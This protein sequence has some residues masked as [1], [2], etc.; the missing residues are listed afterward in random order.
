[1]QTDATYRKTLET[2]EPATEK[3]L[4]DLEKA[5]GFKYRQGIGEILYVMVTCRPDVSFPVVKLS[6]YATA[7]API[8]F[9]AVKQLYLYLKQTQ[10]EGIYYWR[11]KPR[12]DL[13]SGTPPSPTT[14]NNY[15]HE[16]QEKQDHCGNQLTT[17]ADSDH[18]ADA[19]H[20]KSVSGIVHK[21]AGGT[22]HYKSKFQD[23]VA[24]ST[25]EAE[26]IAAAEAGKPC[27]HGQRWRW[28]PVDSS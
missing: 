14:P 20:R 3:E 5:Y 1:M 15:T 17:A 26:F 7:P 18:A 22:I 23:V 28:S 9:E 13:Q 24:L 27:K 25:S 12:M 21:L 16:V 11:R 2:A 4:K 19:K 10:N 6:Q 8:H